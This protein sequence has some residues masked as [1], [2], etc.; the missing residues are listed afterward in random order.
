MPGRGTVGGG[1]AD[2]LPVEA[3]MMARRAL[4]QGLRDGDDHAAV[5]ERARRVLALDLQ[6]QQRHPDGAPERAGVDERREALAEGHDGVVSE[7]RAG[8]PRSAP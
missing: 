4:L 2:V 6:V 1:E 5:L 3:Q 7:S 8:T